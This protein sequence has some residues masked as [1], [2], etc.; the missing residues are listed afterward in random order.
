MRVE[1]VI[2]SVEEGVKIIYLKLLQGSKKMLRGTGL[3]MVNSDEVF[4][5]IMNKDNLPLDPDTIASQDGQS[6][7]D[8]AKVLT[9]KRESIYIDGRLGL[10]IDGT[11]KDVMKIG[12]TQERLQQ[13]GYDTM[14]LFVNTS[15]EVAQQR[16]TKR[17]RS[18]FR[19]GNEHVETSSR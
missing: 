14:M 1:E 17:D 12:K 15:L 16:N 11:G 13:M 18:S 8:N 10:V 7:R 5:L 2:K 9:K 6:R 3:K 19:Y 4:E